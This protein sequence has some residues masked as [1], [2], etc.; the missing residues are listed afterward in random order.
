MPPPVV[1]VT[2]T[3]PV[4]GGETAV[5][6][7]EDE[8][9]TDVACPDPKSTVVMFVVVKNPEPVRVTVVPPKVDPTVGEMEDKA[10]LVVTFGHKAPGAKI[11][12]VG[13]P[14]PLAIS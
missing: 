9:V 1:T 6:E 8:Q 7:V 3:V 2:E 12:A 13:L 10:G 4:P 14:S 11:A 5:H